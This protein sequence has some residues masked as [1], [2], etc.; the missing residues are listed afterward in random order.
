MQTNLN[1]STISAVL[2]LM[3]IAS[4]ITMISL[5]QISYIVHNDLYDFGLQF[6]Y[7]WAMPYWVFSGVVFALCWGNIALSIIFTLYIFR[8]TRKTNKPS[9]GIAQLEEI[10]QSESGEQ[11]K[12]VQYVES[13]KQESTQMEQ[14]TLQTTSEAFVG[15]NTSQ[16][17]R[18]VDT[19]DVQEKQTQ[20]QTTEYSNPTKDP[21]E[22]SIQ[23][24]D[25]KQRQ[26]TV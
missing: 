15:E 13:P 17:V 21:A 26:S 8:K 22:L 11:R 18:E 5:N 4:L 16:I 10:V 3:A 12:L 20:Q 7:R 6:S 1:S 24:E 2:I 23:Q 9:K 19:Q 14:Y 25:T